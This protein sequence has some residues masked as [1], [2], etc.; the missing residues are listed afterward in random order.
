[1]IEDFG[2]RTMVSQIAGI[3]FERAAE[4]VR[5][6]ALVHAEF[7]NSPK[8]ESLAVDADVASIRS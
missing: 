3:E 1:M 6:L 8:L 2:G 7:W 5:A 4:A